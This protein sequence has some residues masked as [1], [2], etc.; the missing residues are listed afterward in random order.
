MMRTLKILIVE[1]T[2]WLERAPHHTHHLMERLSAK[3]HEVRV[4]DF[5][6]RWREHQRTEVISNRTIFTNVHK[7]ID[8]GN[9]S[10]IRPSI[11]K[12]P[13]LEYFSLICAHGLEVR[14][15]IKDFSP[16][17]VVGVGILSANVAMRFANHKSTP[18][19]FFVIDELFRLV[20]QKYFQNIAKHIESQNMRGSKKVICISEGL[21][22]YAIQMGANAKKTVVLKG[23][24]DHKL[25]SKANGTA[26][27]EK[28]G[29]KK[30]DL[31]LFFLGALNA[32]TG[33]R[34][35]ASELA[36]LNKLNVK[37]LIAGEG[38]LCDALQSIIKARGLE[39]RII[40]AGWVPYKEV[41]DYVA[42]SDICILPA[43]KNDI[44]RNIVPIKMYDYI[45]GGKPVIASRLDGIMTE[46]GQNNGVL[47]V[48]GPEDVVKRAIEIAKTGSI[49]EEGMRARRF[50]EKC[51]WDSSTK[52]LEVILERLT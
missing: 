3:G 48:D 37:L 46:F 51:N 45:A 21:R 25:F 28:Y 26:I 6:I 7:A 4:I 22:K 20:P 27:R 30:D 29:I 16:D 9:V 49:K 15:Q 23:G 43:Y 32:Y 5:E 39:G 2:D 14:K 19:V 42:A 50:A 38:E 31:V 35:V 10:V 52:Q 17:V 1:D 24:G 8:E 33:L 18:F 41:P 13:F 34:E 40:T 36:R 12:L 47:H 44:M 11:I